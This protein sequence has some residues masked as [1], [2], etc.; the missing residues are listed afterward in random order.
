MRSAGATSP[1]SD[2]IAMTP[3]LNCGPAGLPFIQEREGCLGVC[4]MRPCRGRTLCEV[5]PRRRTRRAGHIRR[6]VVVLTDNL[7]TQRNR[8]AG[9]A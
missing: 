7:V 5:Q 9:E 1:P 6:H 4:R 8:A 3:A 2:T